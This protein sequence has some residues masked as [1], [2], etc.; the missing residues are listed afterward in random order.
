[1]DFIELSW[2]LTNYD[3]NIDESVGL[4]VDSNGDLIENMSNHTAVIPGI[5]CEVITHSACIGEI[6]IDYQHSHKTEYL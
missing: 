5:R 1:M 4:V 3:N 2:Y 6:I